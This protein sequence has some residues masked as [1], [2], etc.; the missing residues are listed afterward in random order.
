[1]K[2]SLFKKPELYITILIAIYAVFILFRIV[3]AAAQTADYPNEY[4]EAAN[5]AMT[6][7]I[8]NGENIYSEESLGVSVPTVCYLYGP[9]MSLVAA[10]MAKLLPMLSI[11]VIHY[12]I[13]VLSIIFSAIIMMQAV[14]LY[15]RTSIAPAL[16]FVF[17]IF[18][19]WRY[20]YAYGA[21]D[22]FGLCLMITVLY[23]L[24]SS[25]RYE[26]KNRNEKRRDYYVEAAAFL[27][28]CTFFTKQYFLMVAAVGAI[29]L[30]IM[31]RRLFVRYAVSGI[32]FSTVVFWIIGTKC[33]LYFTYAI[34]FLK[35]PGPGAAMGKTGKAYN[36]MQV[37]YLGGMLFMLFL[38]VLLLVIYLGVKCFRSLKKKEKIIIPDM[39]FLALFF[40]QAAVSA[41]VLKYIGNNDGA[42]LS[43]Y[44]Q[45]F[46]PALVALSVY[47]VDH[48]CVFTEGS[49]KKRA[50]F[51]AVYVLFIGYTVYKVEPRLVINMLTDE[52]MSQWRE[53]YET[54]DEYE[55]KGDIY[56]C[57]LLNYYGYEKGDYIYNDGQ[58]FVFTEKFLNSFRES[59]TAQKL[60]PKAGGIIKLH[61]D[62]RESMR[63]RVI[64]GEYALV[65]RLDGM[66]PVFTTE[67]L[68]I[69]YKKLKTLELRAGSWAWDVELWVPKG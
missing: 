9:L 24:I 23:L 1:M 34:Y 67:E 66:D 47:A 4:R 55:G 17:T 14:K 35:G 25:V 46:T 50:V 54:L 65:T 32:A 40:V 2:N 31:S 19:H 21:P 51:I 63:Q 58:P 3:S 22:S 16:A 10:L 27:T 42:F 37:S 64:N 5:I 29:Y 45:L 6:Q 59:S 68:E 41:V 61:L 52:E 44:L 60:F 39:A 33:P 43:Y 69:S 15:T 8:L 57:P 20:G 38:A 30:L 62:F 13:S 18:C 56:Y 26:E 12:I 53:A 11:P 36:S 7:S 48:L 28:L 49:A